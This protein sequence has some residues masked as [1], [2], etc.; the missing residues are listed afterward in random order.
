[1]KKL[2]IL[3]L[4]FPIIGFSQ[5]EYKIESKLYSKGQTVVYM[6]VSPDSTERI[7]IHYRFVGMGKKPDLIG[8]IG[9]YYPDGWGRRKTKFVL[10]GKTK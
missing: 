1:M 7:V 6:A 9:K 5:K 3:S 8:R 2:L 10:I 4:L